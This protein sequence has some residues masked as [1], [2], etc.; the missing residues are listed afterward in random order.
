LARSSEYLQ[1]F[2]E[3]SKLAIQL[4]HEEADSMNDPHARRVLNNLAFHLGNELKRAHRN[5]SGETSDGGA[6][7]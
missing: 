4:A 6:N 3:A 2:R 7:P 5:R 1:G